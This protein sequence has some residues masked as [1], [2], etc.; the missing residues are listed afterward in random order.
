MTDWVRVP[1]PWQWEGEPPLSA[2]ELRARWRDLGGWVS[3]LV[4]RHHLARQIPRCWARHP[5]LVD[6]LVA[7]RHWHQEVTCPLVPLTQPDPVGSPQEPEDPST[8]ARSYWDWHEARWR[9]TT[10]PLREA[11]GYRECLTRGEHVADELHHDDAQA[12][13]EATRIEVDRLLP[14]SP[15]GP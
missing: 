9:W 3:W 11:S 13:A 5:G 8:S 4:A 7:L 14:P 15:E 10:G 6:E 2:A 1:L 12:L